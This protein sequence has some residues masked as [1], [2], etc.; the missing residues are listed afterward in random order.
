MNNDRRIA[1]MGHQTSLSRR[2]SRRHR[3]KINVLLFLTEKIGPEVLPYLLQNSDLNL[4]V[5]SEASKEEFQQLLDDHISLTDVSWYQNSPQDPYKNHSK[6]LGHQFARWADFLFVVVDAGMMALMLAGFTTDVMLHAL[7]C[8][9]TSKRIFLLPEMSV[10]EWEHPLRKK[11]LSELEDRWD[12]VTV[13]APAIWDSAGTKFVQGVDE[14]PDVEMEQ[15]WTW[16]GSAEIIETI[17][18]ETQTLLRRPGNPASA[19]AGYDTSQTVVSTKPRLPME[20]WTTILDHLGDWELAT[21]LGIYTHLPTP[22]EWKEYLPRPGKPRSLEFTIL[23]KPV[24]SVRA[25][26]TNSSK[27]QQ[28][29]TL[30]RLASKIIFKFSMTDLLT[31]LA[32]HQKD[33]F[34]TTFPL[35]LLPHKASVIFNSPQILQWWF[36]CPA[37]IKKEYG[38]EALDGASR[39]GFVEVLDWWLQSG[40]K[41]CYTEK[42]LESASAKG[43]VEVLEWWR[44]ASESRRKLGSENEL[45]LKVGKSILNAAQAGRTD[46]ITWWET[47]GIAYA[48]EADVARLASTHGYV[49]VLDL[50]RNLKGSKMIFDNQVLVGPTK[51]GHAAV[52]QWWKEAS[53][54]SDGIVVEY[55]TCDIEEAMEDAIGG[56]GE[57]E[58]RE[59]WARNGLNLGVGTGEWMRV[60][61]L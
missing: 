39:A 5:I 15:I 16:D 60:K 40:L 61:T 18:S 11:Q 2:P 54:K 3:R 28:S 58:V 21:A 57:G 36:D 35:S 14:C 30:S 38:P 32:L 29:V 22:H 41:L 23:T 49:D 50:W 33:V 13:L 24:S 44:C 1:T 26:F 42:A 53:R 56:G 48:H 20:I 19:N 27:S 43:H 47:S 6:L 25:F 12:W 17:H 8:W 34:W 45:P 52:L 9:D 55:K 4:K 51:N 59:W 37:V 7:R 46:S 31:Y 10:D